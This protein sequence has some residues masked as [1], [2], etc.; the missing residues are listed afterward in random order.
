[1]LSPTTKRAVILLFLAWTID[2]VDRTVI[3]AA[4]TSMGTDLSLD[5]GERGLV[6]SCFFIA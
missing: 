2:Y 3:S 4:L 1:M 6:V 5:H